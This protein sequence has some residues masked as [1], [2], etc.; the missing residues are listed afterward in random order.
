[1]KADNGLCGLDGEFSFFFISFWYARAA[2]VST[3]IVL[4][5]MNDS[6]L[7][8]ISYGPYNMNQMILLIWFESYLMTW[9]VQVKAWMNS[10]MVRVHIEKGHLFRV[11][12]HEVIILVYKN[13][14]HSWS[15]RWLVDDLVRVHL[16]KFIISFFIRKIVQMNSDQII[17]Q[18]ATRS[19]MVQVLIDQNYN[20]M[21]THSK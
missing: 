5:I 3:H 15:G 8:V 2:Q 16:G 10:K 1:M 6:L 11:G 7:W 13:L 21:K 4:V 12:F 20:F 17:N 18:S 19:T 9:Y 14:D